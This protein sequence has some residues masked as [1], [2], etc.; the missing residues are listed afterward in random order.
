MLFKFKLLT[1]HIVILKRT[2]SEI[3]KKVFILHL[4]QTEI[5][6]TSQLEYNLSNVSTTA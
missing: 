2:N 5:R 1:D 6:M 4:S 3:F